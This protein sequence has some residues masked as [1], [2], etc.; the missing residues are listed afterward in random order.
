MND[1]E[2]SSSKL[3][4]GGVSEESKDFNS[5]LNLDMDWGEVVSSDEEI[6][7]FE[8]IKPVFED[9]NSQCCPFI[10]EEKSENEIY[11][12]VLS[13]FQDVH[14]LNIK[15]KD[16]NLDCSYNV[17]RNSTFHM[18][19]LGL[20]K[21]FC[22]NKKLNLLHYYLKFR[23]DFLAL[24]ASQILNL[25]AEKT[26]LKFSDVFEINSKRT[27]DFIFENEGVYHILE[28]SAVTDIERGA[29]SKGDLEYGYKSKYDKEIMELEKKGFKIIYHVLLFDVKDKEN[30][31]FKE[32]IVQISS[33]SNKEIPVKSKLD[34][35]DFFRIEFCNSTR[36]I[37]EVFG[38]YYSNLFEEKFELSSYHCENTVNDLF[39]EPVKKY[40]GEYERVGVS[41]NVYDSVSR[42]LPR[43]EDKVYRLYKNDKNCDKTYNLIFDLNKN[44]FNFSISKLKDGKDKTLDVWY[45]FIEDKRVDKICENLVSVL[46]NSRV[47]TPKADFEFFSYTKINPE[48]KAKKIDFKNSDKHSG[49]YSP[50]KMSVK[51]KDF[52]KNITDKSFKN[53]TSIFEDEDYEEKILKS[54]ENLEVENMCK[55]SKVPLFASF[56]V[57]EKSIKKAVEKFKNVYYDLNKLND[58]SQVHCK[59]PFILPLYKISLESYCDIKKSPKILEFLNKRKIGPY[60]D[61]IIEI[62][63]RD[64]FEFGTMKN[65]GEIAIKERKEL[66][67]LQ[68]NINDELKQKFRNSDRKSHFKLKDLEKNEMYRENLKNLNK[69]IRQ[70]LKNNKSVLCLVRISSKNKDHKKSFSDEMKHFKE[71]KIGKINRGVHNFPDFE[72][73]EYS[74]N[75]LREQMLAPSGVF[76]QD[77]FIDEYV[78]DD[79]KLL[80]DL[81]I[82]A[83]E[84]YQSFIKWVKGSNF[85]STCEF[86]SRFC[87]SLL[88]HSQTSVSGDYVSVDN[89]GYDD[90]LLMV[91]G[92][93]KIFPTKKTKL[94]RLILPTYESCL[95]LYRSSDLP[96]S[97][98]FFEEEGRIFMITPWMNLHETIVCDGLTT[99]HRNIGFLCLNSE[100]YE[101]NFENFNNC[102]FNLLLFFH[103][104]RQTETFL[105]NMRYIIMNSMSDFSAIE[106]ILPEL[107]GFNYDCLQFYIRE[108][109]IRKFPEFASL[110]KDYHDKSKSIKIKDSLSSGK[111]KNMFTNFPI[112]DLNQ[113]ATSVYITYMMSKAPTTQTLEQVSNLRSMMETHESFLKIGTD[114]NDGK[115][116][117]TVDDFTDFKDYSDSLSEN[118]FNFDPKY[119]VLLGKFMGDYLSKTTG[120]GEM[121]RKWSKVL[122]KSW[123]E[124]SNTKGLRGENDSDFFGSKGYLVVYKKIFEENPDFIENLKILLNSERG[125]DAFRNKIKEMNE[126]FRDRVKKE[127]LEVV[128]LHVVDKKQRSGKREIFVMDRK[129]KIYQQ[130]I[131]N[132]IGEIC[133]SLPNELISVP[134]NKRLSTIH[135]K[136]FE[137]YRNNQENYFMVMD[138]RKWAPKSIIQKFILFLSGMRKILPSNFLKHCYNF[139]DLL[140]SKR[141]YTKPHIIDIIG[142][143]E[144]TKDYVKYFIKDEERKGYYYKMIYSWMM[145]I[146]NYFSSFMHVAN[147]MH[148]SHISRIHFDKIINEEVNLNM[149]A[150][151]DDSAGKVSVQSKN[152][153]KRLLIIYEILMKASNHLISKKK[154]NCGKVYYE[155]ISILYIDG[156]LLSLVIKFAGLFNFHPTDKGYSADINE[157][158]SKSTELILNGSTLSQSYIGMK[159]QSNLIRRFYFNKQSEKIFYK[160]PP[161]MMGIPDAHPLMILLCGSEADTLRIKLTCDDDHMKMI[162]FLNNE[163]NCGES[164]VEGFLKSF[165]CTPNVRARKDLKDLMSNF[166]ISE[167]A[168]D[169]L[170]KNVDF[171]NTLMNS[172]QFL[173][174][175]RDKSFLAALQ[176][177]SLTRRIS[178]A[179]FYRSSL[180]LNTKYGPLSFKNFSEIIQLFLTKN[181]NI[182]L[183]ID[184]KNKNI[185]DDLNE[186]IKKNYKN[187]EVEKFEKLLICFFSEPLKLC[188]YMK[189]VNFKEENV[190]ISLKTTKPLHIKVLN[191]TEKLPF[192]VP[193][194]SL[195]AWIK[196]PEKRHLLPDTRNMHTLEKFFKNFL[197][198]FEIDI[199]ELSVEEINSLLMRM[200]KKNETEYFCYSNVPSQM[201][202]I[203]TYQD[204]LNFLSHNTYRNKY[205]EGLTVKFGR[206]MSVLTQNVIKNLGG[207]D[208]DWTLSF[209]TLMMIFSKHEDF[210]NFKKLKLKV[211][212]FISDKNVNLEEVFLIM[213]SYWKK[214]LEVY[215]YISLEI[216][217]A[218]EV[219]L[220]LKMDPLVLEKCYFNSFIKTQY[221]FKNTWMGVA[222][223]YINMIDFKLNLTIK[224]NKV[225]NVICNDFDKFLDNQELSYINLCLKNAQIGFL[226][227]NFRYLEP[228]ENK[229][230]FLGIDEN[231]FI[232]ICKGSELIKGIPA[233]MDYNLKTILSK[234]GTG[235][236]SFNDKGTLRWFKKDEF[237]EY[238]YKI[239]TI[240]IEMFNSLKLL[241]GLIPENFENKMELKEFNPNFKKE[242]YEYCV[243]KL[244]IEMT[245]NKEE[246]LSNFKASEIYKII[247]D[248]KGSQ[249][250]IIVPKEIRKK[251]YPA[252]DGGFLNILINYAQKNKNFDFD[253]EKNLSP[254]YIKMKAT[255]PE[256]FMAVLI[257]NVEKNYNDLYD[258]EDKNLI[259]RSL[260]N[261]TKLNDEN[262]DEK[263]LEI[264]CNWSYAGV[265][266]S[267]SVLKKEIKAE[268][269]KSIRFFN[270]SFP[271]ISLFENLTI[272]LY[273]AIFESSSYYLSKI[274]EMRCD[275]NGWEEMFVTYR[276]YEDILRSMVHSDNVSRYGK[277]N[278]PPFFFEMRDLYFFIFIK[279][280]FSEEK[281]S[282]IF[283]EII[284]QSNILA[285]LPVGFKFID[286]WVIVYNSLRTMYRSKRINHFLDLNKRVER[287][288]DNPNPFVLSRD[289]LKEIGINVKSKSLIYHGILEESFYVDFKDKK[290]FFNYKKQIFRLNFKIVNPDKVK[291]FIFNKD[292]FPP[293]VLTEDFL[294]SEEMEEIEMELISN[295][296]DV[297]NINENLNNFDGQL[298]EKNPSKKIKA[299]YNGKLTDVLSVD[300]SVLFNFVSTGKGYILDKVRQSGQHVVVITDYLF[301]VNPSFYRN[302][303][304]NAYKLKDDYWGERKAFYRKKDFFATVFSYFENVE[305][306]EDA[307][308]AKIIGSE[309]LRSLSEIPIGIYYNEN[310]LIVNNLKIV[311][312]KAID[313]MNEMQKDYDE[314]KK[315][316]KEAMEKETIVIDEIENKKEFYKEKGYDIDFIEKY[317]TGVKEK[318][319]NWE[320]M[321][322]FLNE[323]VKNEK[324]F[325]KLIGKIETK[326][327]EIIKN[328]KDPKIYEN[329]F[330]IPK[331]LGISR[332]RFS[333]SKNFSLKEQNL[334]AEIESF[335]P[336]FTSKLLSDT[337]TITE[338]MR[339]RFERRFKLMKRI[340]P[341]LKRNKEGKNFL[342]NF[343]TLFVNDANTDEKNKSSE[344]D[345]NWMDILDWLD[346]KFEEDEDSSSDELENNMG[347]GEPS[348]ANL[349]YSPK[350]F[351]MEK[352]ES[353]MI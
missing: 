221:L 93:K 158:Y 321:F 330:Q 229:D 65:P 317:L 54:M 337:L 162:F 66:A 200:E 304:I 1:N 81:K 13:L 17:I 345:E 79:V 197:T 254:A 143:N 267:V 36:F 291:K 98:D 289:C 224:N 131:E 232:R 294:D 231:N 333:D 85:Y 292:F 46:L 45:R 104:R 319:E 42:N 47:Q 206:S 301:S 14:S 24:K 211:P 296:A 344:D 342:M 141:V 225:I 56:E 327:S 203:S 340:S 202:D 86:S 184:E 285:V 9:K 26:D 205:I 155:F 159:I 264:L 244:S 59:Q 27:P 315:A 132:Y 92:G 193:T 243:K 20:L 100:Y 7:D 260:V 34:D 272:L 268:N 135:S 22:E 233:E 188:S 96:S 346:K 160:I 302:L 167:L 277:K 213:E 322:E 44:S 286:N 115:I 84:K 222:Q 261:S 235:T 138:C 91:K 134:S 177:E 120:E 335:F 253:W 245:I 303:K 123:D 68:R 147:Q 48:R 207:E 196:Y 190:K 210:K 217:K 35:L 8:I 55:E 57:S 204:V 15:N 73:V 226:S 40:E 247:N 149:I 43:L 212:D 305:M 128:I 306:W 168:D 30:D 325:Q 83:I 173:I 314:K 62:I 139:F 318:S 114:I 191:T 53:M 185:I 242:I 336:G 280:I 295:E 351:E 274:G 172:L 237:F 298:Y 133:K 240:P 148:I 309:S 154:S 227:E 313:A 334:I 187:F 137:G 119:C 178:R 175:I 102:F 136:V 156:N 252:Q 249:D 216:E 223:L 324:V 94:F 241:S 116:Y 37:S 77:D 352:F 11:E 316:E 299:R 180:S 174:K 311:E 228:N 343:I 219:C 275:L 282:S 209:I 5:K 214:N 153:M 183:N 284:S 19:N 287:I 236:V 142:K 107:A 4:S 307:L 266:G 75:N 28:I 63:S 179:Y 112:K 181:E 31:D 67:D 99:L 281:T 349:K 263:M 97:F 297:D 269:F 21:D 111:L 124:F 218:R 105:H 61:K 52:S 165:D 150:H 90:V 101:D 320:Y 103:N 10:S 163:L 293:H 265:M 78:G 166:D 329:I 332:E 140:C 125:D 250:C 308:H 347:L 273:K 271:F 283:K 130:L 39:G 25:D 248:C 157:A 80:K 113:L 109:V 195:S 170:I 208:L 326:T 270:K 164:A 348:N 279:N 239:E 350:M 238:N 257:K 118:D 108:C 220:G 201:R 251:D 176:D 32:K 2:A 129:T 12:E 64:E 38:E 290:K 255:Q 50:S 258:D 144:K 353:L 117:K 151:S 72:K 58:F 29:L 310:G 312:M 49:S 88:Y 33:I 259:M 106:E 16:L 87:H 215:K 145:G 51:V 182:P 230:L 161:K 69:I 341:T 339:K 171:K 199:S 246:I 23:H 60:T 126:T 152:S 331:M 338:K 71:K 234:P 76:C 198:D 189:N 18:L 6:E 323:M 3:P 122:G 194:Q 256:A 186:L 328:V 276:N 192:K 288:E 169:W 127:S 82:S 41:S 89:L 146:F 300:V 95:D 121:H 70:K 278:C 110:L 262:F 74:I